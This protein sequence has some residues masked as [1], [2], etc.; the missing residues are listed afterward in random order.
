MTK[1]TENKHPFPFYG[2]GDAQ[3]YEWAE[4]IV[5]F[6]KEPTKDQIKKITTLAPSPIKPEKEDFRGKMLVAGGGQCIN[7]DIHKK[8]DGGAVPKNVI[9]DFGDKGTATLFY[10]SEK[11]LNAFNEHIEKWLLEIHTLCPI[12]F[13]YRMEDGEAGGTKLSDWHKKSTQSIK[14]LIKELIKDKNTFKQKGEE[15]ELFTHSIQGIFA[16]SKIKP[17]QI[18]SQLLDFTSPIHKIGLLFKKGK[19]KDI[20]KF[21]SKNQKEDEFTNEVSD[22]LKNIN[23]ENKKERTVFLALSKELLQSKITFLEEDVEL[24]TKVAKAAIIAKNSKLLDFL[25]KIMSNKKLSPIYINTIGFHAYEAQQEKKYTKIA[26]Q[27]YELALSIKVKT[28]TTDLDLSTYCNALWVLQNDNTGLPA[29]KKLNQAFLEKCLPFGPKNPAIYFN[30]LCLYVEMNDLDQAFTCL[31]FVK[32]Y[33]FKFINEG[34][35]DMLIKQLKT[36][37]LFIKLRH[38]VRYKEIKKTL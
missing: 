37:K 26:I 18:P 24:I 20:I 9:E 25:K 29:N 6:I 5:R 3:Y 4:V 33:E 1:K 19:V 27:L 32:K 16:F 14:F 38:D 11:A 23:T 28:I 17:S 36:E 21:I 2:A 15:K 34:E 35:Y 30:A 31:T 22:Y 7:M 12:Q 10:C 8:Y 13:A